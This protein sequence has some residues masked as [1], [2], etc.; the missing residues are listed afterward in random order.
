MATLTETTY[1]SRKTIKFTGIG[2]AGYILLQILIT[3]GIKLYRHLNPPPPP[4]PTVG[5]GI[6]PKIEFPDNPGYNYKLQLEIPTGSF[7]SFP[8]RATVYYMP[9]RKP[10]LLALDEATKLATKLRF[11]NQP[12][13]LSSGIY[14]WEKN[15]P[16]PLI[17]KINSLDGS[18]TL[19][20]QWQTD[21]NLLLDKNLQGRE[22]TLTMAKGFFQTIGLSQ[23]DIDFSKGK[24]AYLKASG[25]KMI[26]VNSL[27]EADFVKIDFF[28]DSIE[29][30]AVM[31]PNPE[32]GIISM[33]FSGSSNS[34]KQ[35]IS[36]KYNYFPA[37][38]L[39]PE[40]YPIKPAAAAWEELRAGKAYIARNTLDSEEI[41]IRRVYL[42]YYDSDKPQQF[43]QPVYMFTDDDENPN[44]IAYV[45]AITND[46]VQQEIKVE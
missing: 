7:P 32:H 43:L 20:Y 9:F 41:S 26:P 24:V 39:A 17:L 31:T 5:F 28:R 18:F 40:T 10:S 46:F 2:I 13:D 27:S 34:E 1:Y 37:N 11:T 22:R 29:Y 6:L 25:N 44:F 3:N 16:S 38:Y 21:S 12:K 33:I 15:I 8:D 36:V 23:P 4:P 45:P 35:L 14:E 19:S 30:Y 42:A